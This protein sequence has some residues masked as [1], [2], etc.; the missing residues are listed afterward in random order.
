MCMVSFLCVIFEYSS[1][2]GFSAGLRSLTLRGAKSPKGIKPSCRRTLPNIQNR[3]NGPDILNLREIKQSRFV[4][5]LRG[6]SADLWLHHVRPGTPNPGTS[7]RL[8]KKVEVETFPPNFVPNSLL[9]LS[10]I[11]SNEMPVAN[12][13][14]NPLLHDPNA[15]PPPSVTRNITNRDALPYQ[16][17][18][19][20]CA[21][22]TIATPHY[23]TNASPTRWATITNREAQPPRPPPKAD[24]YGKYE[25][26]E[27]TQG[28]RKRVILKKPPPQSKERKESQTAESSYS[29]D[30]MMDGCGSRSYSPIDQEPRS[31][32]K[33]TTA[34]AD[35]QLQSRHGPPQHTVYSPAHIKEKRQSVNHLETGLNV[36]YMRASDSINS[37]RRQ[38]VPKRAQLP[39]GAAEAQLPP[40]G[41]YRETQSGEDD[42]AQ[43]PQD[44]TRKELQRTKA[45]LQQLEYG[46]RRVRGDNAQLQ[47]ACLE[48]DTENRRQKDTIQSLQREFTS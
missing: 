3:G 42:S 43:P 5:P 21:A 22:S 17:S 1:W 10:Q 9:W 24:N 18:Q 14:G 20:Q 40:T 15:P 37:R 46:F 11:I 4:Y 6:S 25:D 19:T 41:R 2:R 48:L 47:R 8:M 12:P 34:P 31:A 33:A 23:D 38:L 7:G 26:K 27:G 30:I 29:V 44:V 45:K 36:S 39:S 13:Y 28:G 32:P 35:A 16:S